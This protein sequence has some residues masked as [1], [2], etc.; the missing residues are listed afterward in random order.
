MRLTSLLRIHSHLRYRSPRDEE[1]LEPIPSMTMPMPCQQVERESGRFAPRHRWAP[2]AG[3]LLVVDV[4]LVLRSLAGLGIHGVDSDICRSHTARSPLSSTPAALGQVAYAG[5]KTERSASIR[6]GP[7]RCC[8]MSRCSWRNR[9]SVS[10]G[11]RTGG[12]GSRGS[13]RGRSPLASAAC[14]VGEIY[15]PLPPPGEQPCMHSTLCA[16]EGGCT[17][18]PL[19]CGRTACRSSPPSQERVPR[20]T[21]AAGRWAAAPLAEPPHWSCGVVRVKTYQ[22]SDPELFHPGRSSSPLRSD[23]AQPPPR[24]LWPTP[25]FRWVRIAAR[26]VLFMGSHQCD[27]WTCP[28][29]VCLEALSRI[30]EAEL[31]APRGSQRPRF[32]ASG[33]RSF[34]RIPAGP[35]FE[36]Q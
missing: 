25:A 29:L 32:S 31:P 2:L 14:S 26:Y 28:A 24:C 9:S 22:L 4:M 5:G 27:T 17:D 8:A 30:A 6:A 10:S 1:E 35:G 16:K 3:V 21:L 11:C 7:P 33:P 34:L 19:R 20:V 13:S 15:A 36:E 18:P 23:L 12:S